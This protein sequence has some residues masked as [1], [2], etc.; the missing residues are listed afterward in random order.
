MQKLTLVFVCCAF[1]MMA[2][3]AG[4]ISAW[5]TRQ[6]SYTYNQYRQ[7]SLSVPPVYQAKFQYDLLK[8]ARSSRL[9]YCYSLQKESRPQ[10][11]NQ[12][13]YPYYLPVHQPVSHESQQQEHAYAHGISEHDG[14][15]WL[16]MNEN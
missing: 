2:A 8:P 4:I 15:V 3:F 16:Y 11:S 10:R 7:L 6:Q 12:S 9:A 14:R 13:G 1:C 5:K